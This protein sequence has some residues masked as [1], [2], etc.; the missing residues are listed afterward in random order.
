[1][2]FTTIQ[3]E[4]IYTQQARIDQDFTAVQQ[5]TITID[6]GQSFGLIPVQITPDTAPELPE[7]FKIRLLDVELILSDDVPM[8]NNPDP[9]NL[10]QIGGIRN[11]ES[12]AEIYVVIASNDDANGVFHIFSNDP[13]A[14][15]N[16]QVVEVEER[17]RLSVELVVER[18]G[19]LYFV[20]F[21]ISP[22]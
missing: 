13:S 17:D 19:K 11:G 4:V 16:G 20:S 8:L 21:R 12:L 3:A 18:Q 15:D 22:K 6:N 14:L 5:Q 1:M 7:K 2:L 9:A 10:P